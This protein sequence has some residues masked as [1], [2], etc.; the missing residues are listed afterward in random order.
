[1][2]HRLLNLPTVLSFAAAGVFFVWGL[3]YDKF[4]VAGWPGVAK[5]GVIYFTPVSVQIRTSP[6]DGISAPLW[7]IA[8][9]LAVTPHLVRDLSAKLR[10][11]RRTKGL[12]PSCGYDLTGNVSG[13]CPE[14]GAAIAVP[15]PLAVA[16]VQP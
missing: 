11:R 10:D 6:G 5:I 15:P 2:K 12:C 1:M 4:H 16:A 3:L 8:L 7:A 14:C 13:R 9:L